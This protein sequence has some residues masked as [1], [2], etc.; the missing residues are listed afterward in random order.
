MTS[1]DHEP[2]AGRPID[3]FDVAQLVEPYMPA[4]QGISNF[5]LFEYRFAA[6]VWLH[7]TV[8]T[9]LDAEVGRLLTIR[10]S[11][12]HR[13]PG[14]AGESDMTLDDSMGLLQYDAAPISAGAIVAGCCS[15]L[16]S[17]LTYL[18][19]AGQDVA[20]GGLL[21][22]V[23]AL[24]ELLP[25]RADADLVIDNARWLAERRNSFAHRLLDE[26]GLW[27][28]APGATSF[29]FDDELVEESFARLGEIAGILAARYEAYSSG[30]DGR[31][32]SP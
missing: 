23:R 27:D 6:L 10:R 4:G 21:R 7:R 18:P 25:D 13:I 1:A 3:H 16:E 11:G 5:V 31:D 28:K 19:S 24:V 17:L 22:K 9:A 32:E 30:A 20:R 2:D 8:A 29:T 14:W 12:V 15:A 26:G